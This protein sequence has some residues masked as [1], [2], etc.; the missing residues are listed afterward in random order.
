RD[1]PSRDLGE[2]RVSLS[3]V[4]TGRYLMSAYRVGHGINDVYTEYLKL[5]SPWSLT[6]QQVR[7]LA[8][9][10]DGRRVETARVVITQSGNFSHSF[11]IR[12]NDVCLVTLL[13]LKRTESKTVKS[14][15]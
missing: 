14:Q 8:A 15:E 7:G 1:L 4:P 10:N 3:G 6:R 12:E 5:G 11:A 13:P 2:V 9:H